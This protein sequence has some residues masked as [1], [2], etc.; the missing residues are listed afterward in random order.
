[1]SITASPADV[2]WPLSVTGPSASGIPS[3]VR[4]VTM[5]VRSTSTS[6][7]ET[8]TVMPSGVHLMSVSSPFA[9]AALHRSGEVHAS[10]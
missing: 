6:P 2:L 7:S 3:S 9:E 5:R 4:T 1:M 10:P 8:P